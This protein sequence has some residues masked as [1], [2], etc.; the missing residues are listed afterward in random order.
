MNETTM[1]TWIIPVYNGEKYLGQA[2]ESILRQPCGDFSIIVVD[3]G[4]K[5]RSLEIARSYADSRIQVLHKEN[6]GVSSAR[7]MGIDHAKSKYIA[8]L[9]ADDVV[10]R[11][12]YNEQIYM[13]LKKDCYDVVSLAYYTGDQKLKYGNYRPVNKV[14]EQVGDGT[15]ADPYK[16][17]CSSIY[18]TQ[19]LNGEDRIRFPEGVKVGEDAAFMFLLYCRSQRIYYL[20]HA[21]FVYRSNPE[22]T[23]HR[24]KNHEHMIQHSIPAWN[25]C[26]VKCATKKAKDCCDAWMFSEITEYIRLCSRE[27]VPL[28]RIQQELKQP[29]I[30][31]VVQN[32]DVLWNRSKKVYEAFVSQPEEFWREQSRKGFADRVMAWLAGIPA[33]RKV[34][35][36]LKSKENLRTI[37]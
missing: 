12:A 1:L 36:R 13:L 34:Y 27:N 4:S 15:S 2:I 5:D 16:S 24:L 21:W 23:L 28:E 6:G 3:D 20:D 26:K 30:E 31:E 29:L 17:F 32:Y 19:L 11:D 18:R 33:I 14:G 25:W 22:S 9:D 37:V 7:N 35:M 10:C 8:F